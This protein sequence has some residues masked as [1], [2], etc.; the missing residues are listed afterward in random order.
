MVME[1]QAQIQ[2]KDT[3]NRAVQVCAS[4]CCCYV[5]ESDDLKITSSLLNIQ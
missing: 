1:L 2:H 5:I 3:E 4:G